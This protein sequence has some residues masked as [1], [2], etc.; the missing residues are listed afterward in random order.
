[1][2]RETL[3]TPEGLDELKSK[4]EH[5]ST[6]RRR[7]VADRIETLNADPGTRSPEIRRECE[8][9]RATARDLAH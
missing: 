4:I 2:P 1:M 9:L 5:L 8:R 7:E 3:L 6:E